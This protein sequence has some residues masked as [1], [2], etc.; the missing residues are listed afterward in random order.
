M[1]RK[2]ALAAISVSVV[3]ILLIAAIDVE[4][5]SGENSKQNSTTLEGLYYT[6][7]T[8]EMGEPVVFY[9]TQ[10][11]DY[12]HDNIIVEYNGKEVSDFKVTGQV[13]TGKLTIEFTDS[14]GIPRQGDMSGL[15]IIPNKIV[16]MDLDTSNSQWFTNGRLNVYSSY[17]MDNLANDL[18]LDKIVLGIRLDGSTVALNHSVDSRQFEIEGN[19]SYDKYTDNNNSAILTFTLLDE[20]GNPVLDDEQ[21]IQTCMIDTNV[22]FDPILLLP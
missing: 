13:S 5:V 18:A 2:V 4:D 14:D 9:D 12:I 3:A 1:W 10:T 6:I 8:D 19:L 21:E 16:S 11:L 15:N 22:T 17:T 20:N 7:K